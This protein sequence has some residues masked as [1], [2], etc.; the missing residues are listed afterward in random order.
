MTWAVGCGVACASALA[1]A[2]AHG[3]FVP[4]SRLWGR[5][6]SRGPDTRGAVALTFDDG[7]TPGG[8]DRVLDALGET[9]V[10]A[11]FFV[12]GRNALRWPGLVAR[13]HAEGHVVANHTLDHA[14]FGL[15]RRQAYWRRQIDETDAIVRD[16]IGVRPA[17]FRPP[18]GIKTWRTMRVAA[19]SGHRV[20]TWSR[21]AFDGLGTSAGGIIA[22]LGHGSRAGDILLLH[23]GA[24]PL[25][26]GRDR[27][28]TV[29]AIRPLVEGLRSRGLEPVRLDE[30][31]GIDAYHA[32]APSAV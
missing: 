20:V 27:S 28:A 24:E 23:D 9:R 8:T 32:A 22:R 29:A 10:R 12:I 6:I 2:F 19:S 3:T 15:F 18:V 16:I 11:A 31:L 14:H 5:V 13:M 4:S 17:L 30:L 26:Q 25:S 21:R 1:G 7:P